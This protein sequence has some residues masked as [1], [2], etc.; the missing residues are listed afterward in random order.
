MNPE[1]FRGLVEKIE[2]LTESTGL[3]GRKPGDK[4][5]DADTEEEIVFQSMDFYPEGGGALGADDL[6]K[7]IKD[8]E[9]QYGNQ[10]KWE[11][12]RSPKTGGF[13]IATFTTP[14]GTL[15]TGTY[16]QNVKGNRTDNF[17]SNTILGKYKYAGKAAQKT[18][19][20][21]APQDLIKDKTNLTV[22]DIMNQLAKALGTDSTLYYIADHVANGR[23]L[24]VVVDAPAGV[25]FT[26]F[27][28]YFCE[29]LQPIALHTGLY[30]GNA[31]VAAD[32]FLAPQGF[33]GTLINFDASKNANLADSTLDLPDG[34]YVKVS[35]K[36][37]KGA[38]ASIKNLI[39]SVNSLGTSP[40]DI[41]LREKYKSV[42]ELITDVKT[43]GQAGSPLFLG[44][45]YKLITPSEAKIIQ[46]LKGAAPENL[47]D[48]ARLKSLGL[49][50]NLIELSTERKTKTPGAVSLYYHLIASIAH[51]VAE[52]INDETDFS[53]AA[54]TI[55]NNGA[56]I[57]VYTKATERGKKW[58]LDAFNTVYPSESV[59]GVKFSAQK[60]Y[61]ST[62]IKGNFTFKILHGAAEAPD[63]GNIE[64]DAVAV[65]KSAEEPAKPAEK[66]FNPLKDQ[67]AGLGAGRQKR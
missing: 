19:A 9:T 63:E 12:S 43:A 58:S 24:P 62:A 64:V 52:I 41:K 17:I 6:T 67:P 22:A 66:A 7:A 10:I 42:I 35:S 13:A 5:R 49:T 14:S 36:G 34:R 23:K 38:E 56:L 25:S 1:L 50:P 33:A 15:V 47:S 60:N 3:S 61:S 48:K 54:S 16:L 30:T 59:T 40:Q 46:G 65:D 32:K 2:I 18:Q 31:A 29:I 20:G 39:D 51:K 44:V 8:V 27:R 21:L 4:F 26:A 45:K 55:L 53:D 37:D 57:Q 11:N 28:D